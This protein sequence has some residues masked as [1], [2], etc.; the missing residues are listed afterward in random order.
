M[1]DQVLPTPRLLELD[2]V[3]LSAPPARVWQLLRHEDLATSPLIQALFALREL[4]R[5]LR[6]E[7]TKLGLRL[8]DLRSS[9]ETPGFQLLAE[10]ASREL[11]VGAI[12]KVW[13]AQ[14]PFVHVE[15]ARQYADFTTPGFVKVA[16]ALRVLPRGQ[17]DCRV[18]IE[19]RV[20]ATDEESWQKFKRYFLL[21][22]PGSH[23][24]RRTLLGS[25]ARRL[26]TPEALENERALA[27]D[28]LLLDAA[29]QV[30]HGITVDATPD[31]IWPWLVQ[32]G[33]GRGG[34]YAIDALDNGFQPSAREVHPELQHLEVGQL[35]AAAPNDPGGF[36]VL[37]IDAQRALVLGGLFDSRV[38]KQLAFAAPRP[39]SFWQVTWA[40]ALEPL[41]AK[42]TRITVRAR[43]A[44]SKDRLLHLAQLRPVHHL[45]QTAQLR[46]LAAR[47]E[48]RLPR[49][50][51]LDVLDG[52]RGVVVLIGALASPFL[53]R[54]RS[55]WG[56]SEA[57]AARTYPGDELVPEPLWSYTHGVEVD[58]PS[59]R[60]YG[61]IAQIG[62]DRGGFYSYQWLENLVGCDV[63]NAERIHPEW[64][65]RVGQ[66]LL[67]HP[68][69]GAPRLEIVAVEQGSYVLAHAR[70][71][72]RARASGKPWA[73]SSWLFFVQ[74]LG[75]ARC[76]V[77][78]RFRAACSEDLSTRL[79]FGPTLVEPVGFAMDRRMLLGLKERAERSAT[80]RQLPR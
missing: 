4:P 5:R 27:G 47:V 70:G 19:V 69:P 2:G 75:D 53:R 52:L 11:V 77:I 80:S 24:I 1:L 79:A 67:L 26:G 38:E 25:L 56:L 16:W 36:E 71:D 17:S 73:T 22:G 28:E 63:R 62:A 7:H 55:H 32:M 21:V 41:D 49:D 76:R 14:I 44:F 58:A 39:A 59:A 3:D 23:F 72:Q 50:S 57:E 65:A 40:F 60:A 61:W 64:Q 33:C 68:G 15:G 9:A 66:E 46:H 54:A 12:G 42:T 8:D 74:P 78:S 35:L 13:Q 30:T 45:M 37:R 29:A 48:G 51:A 43:A 31:A 20:D 34:F 6:G 10:D 18:E